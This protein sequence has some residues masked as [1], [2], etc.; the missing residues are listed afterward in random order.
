M[1]NLS[2]TAAP[3][4]VWAEINLDNLVHNFKAAQARAS[5]SIVMP[6]IKAD[7]YGHG[8]VRA[9]HTLIEAGAEIFAVTSAGEA[10]ELRGHGIGKKI[11]LLGDAPIEAVKK[12]SGMDT[13]LT[14]SSTEK[15]REYAAAL[16]GEAVAV[17]IKLDT[18]MR[19]LGVDVLGGIESAAQKMIEIASVP[20]ISV[21]GAFTHFASADDQSEEQFTLEQIELFTRAIDEYIRLGGAPLVRHCSNSAGIVNYPAARFDMVRPGLILYGYEP[22]W[23]SSGLGLLPVMSFRSVVT[24][25]IHTSNG[26]SA[27]YGRTWKS[28]GSRTIATVSIGYADG[29]MRGLS[30]RI[31]MLVRGRRAPQAGRI[32]MDMCMIDVTDIPN[33]APGDIVT[34]FGQDGSDSITARDLSGLLDTIPYEILCA[35]SKRVPRIYLKNGKVAS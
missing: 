17:H 4:R 26:E 27:S 12:L 9:A 29:L 34:V 32:C 18:G 16:A 22:D 35:V 1:A 24:H 5:G 15:A 33:V 11:M 2:Q 6:V 31:D 23:G 19:R 21:T 28:S 10:I 7:A 3:H 25:V 8:A 30:G 13:I 20:G 14:A